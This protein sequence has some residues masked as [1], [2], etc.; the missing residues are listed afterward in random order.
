[1]AQKCKIFF[2]HQVLRAGSKVSLSPA[3][4]VSPAGLQVS[5]PGH[6]VPACIADSLLGSWHCLR[7]IL[8][9]FCLCLCVP[10]PL[11]PSRTSPC[12]E[13]TW[14]GPVRARPCLPL[15]WGQG[16]LSAGKTEWSVN[17]FCLQGTERRQ[18]TKVLQIGCAEERHQQRGC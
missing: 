8:E 4:P 10:P 13:A 15:P 3:A 6:F 2:C 11:Y 16:Q 7:S 14:L 1:M 18:G 9:P 17:N 12:M 5:T